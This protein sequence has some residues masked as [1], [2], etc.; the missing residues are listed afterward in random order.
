MSKFTRLSTNVFLIAALISV[1]ATCSAQDRKKR[2][3]SLAN[4]VNK[5]YQAF[6]DE[7]RTSEDADFRAQLIEQAETK[8]SALVKDK[9]ESD[10][11]AKALPQLAKIRLLDIDTCFTDTFEKH[12]ENSVKALSLYSFAKYCGNNRRDE[13]A[14]RCFQLLKEH[15]GD[16][17]FGDSN[18]SMAADN[19][20]YFLENLAVGK[21]APEFAGEDTD[22][23]LF[24]LKDYRGKVVMLRFWGDWCPA[25]RAMYPFE[26]ELVK[27]HKNKAFALIGVNSDSLER[28]RDAQERDNLVWRTIWDGGTTT[29]PTSKIFQ[30]KQWPTII[31]I[32][33]QGVIRLR[34]QGLAEDQLNEMLDR[35]IQEAEDNL[36]GKALDVTEAE[37]IPVEV[38]STISS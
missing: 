26:R 10:E 32:D 18:Y 13:K 6:V 17:P 5:T 2:K 9:V 3:T 15:F 12:P 35:L 14:T 24:R 22:G 27:K 19:A 29:G 4:Q 8:I 23:V 1:T 28:C 38:V 7:F 16:L 25:C 21:S 37:E 36:S 20:I 31:V 33:A 30:V 11:I 34:T